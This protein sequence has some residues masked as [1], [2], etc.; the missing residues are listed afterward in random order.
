MN[1]TTTNPLTAEARSLRKLRELIHAGRQARA[2]PA[3]HTDKRRRW[4][5]PGDA[6]VELEG[7]GALERRL[8]GRV[9]SLP[10]LAGI[11]HEKV[12]TPRCRNLNGGFNRFP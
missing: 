12:E 8:G 9:R 5:L 7:W 4:W 11:Q 1:R 10:S 3:S 6:L 2:I